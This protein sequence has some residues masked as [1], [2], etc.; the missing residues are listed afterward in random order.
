[1]S[2]D[3]VGNWNDDNNIDD[4]D[5]NDDFEWFMMQTVLHMRHNGKSM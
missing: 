4:Y 5:L 3:S 2:D 1:M